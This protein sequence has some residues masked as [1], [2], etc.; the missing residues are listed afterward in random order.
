MENK[1]EIAIDTFCIIS[2]VQAIFVL[3]ILL[4]VLIIKTAAPKL[5][6]EINGFY[7]ESFLVETDV[8]DVLQNADEV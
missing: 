6:S 4:S 2:A 8:N 5:Y 3:L 7:A 1:P